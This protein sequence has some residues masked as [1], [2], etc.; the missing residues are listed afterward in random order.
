MSLNFLSLLADIRHQSRWQLALCL[1]LSPVRRT[2]ANM[3]VLHP[4]KMRGVLL[5]APAAL[6][7]SIFVPNL[8]HALFNSW[9]WHLA[10]P[11][12]ATEPAFS[13]A[14]AA[15][16]FFGVTENP[17]ASYFLAFSENEKLPKALQSGPPRVARP[18]ET[19]KGQCVC[20]WPNRVS[21]F[22]RL[23]MARS[24]QRLRNRFIQQRSDDQSGFF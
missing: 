16:F 19:W 2:H 8:R 4:L 23:S 3:Q 20:W 5:Y 6:L 17:V 12:T 24:Q 10:C 9:V 14:T 21:L 7:K 15:I 1:L 11:R 18:N 22:N 13:K